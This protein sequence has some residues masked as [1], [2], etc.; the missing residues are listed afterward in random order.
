MAQ[1]ALDNPKAGFLEKNSDLFLA[2]GV[3]AVLMLM[4]VPLSAAVLDMFLVLSIAMSLTVLLLAIYVTRPLDLSLFPTIL[5]L[6]TMYRL[7]LN[8]ASTRLILLNGSQG[9]SAAGVV[10]EAFGQFVVGGDEVV[11]LIVFI[12]INIINFVVITKGA[13]RISEVSARFTLDAMP[14]KQLAIDAD[15]NA[16][17][18]NDREAKERREAVQK[19]ADFYGSMDGASKFVKGDAIAGVLITLINI[20]GGFIIGMVKE[21]LDFTEALSVYT[22][23]TIGDGLV[24]QVPSLIISFSAGML[25]TKV[26]K[27]TDLKTLLVGQMLT[28]YRPMMVVAAILFLIG[29]VPGLPA[30]PFFFMAAIVGGIAFMIK[31]GR[32][33]TQEKQS[34][35][36]GKTTGDDSKPKEEAQSDIPRV[37]DI[38]EIEVGYDLVPLVSSKKNND[39][40]KRILA[41]RKQFAEEMG[42][43]VPPIH[44]QDNLQLKGNE[45]NILLKSVSVGKGELLPGH[46]LAMESGKLIRT[47]DG[48]PTKEPTYNLPALWISEAKK[49][50]A[51]VAGYTVV[52]L[53]SVLATHLSELI[54]KHSHKIFNRQDLQTLLDEFKK[55]YP[56]VVSDLIPELLPF[57]TV[58]KVL[59]NLLKERV[60]IRDLLTILEALASEAPTI[61]DP[62]ALTE[63]VRQSLGPMITSLYKNYKNQIRALGLDKAWEDRLNASIQMTNAGPE[64]HVDPVTSQKLIERVTQKISQHASPEGFP[65]VMCSQNVRPHL[66]N[67]LDKFIPSVVVLSHNE[68]AG[69]ADVLFVDNIA[70]RDK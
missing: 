26:N 11:G 60:P 56:K 21:N 22:I 68:V 30:G 61:K 33:K 20:V 66:F 10:I 18:I 7:A 6:A 5:L 62:S 63:C 16:G 25:V 43:M 14:G 13:G 1:M 28:E 70:E 49:E 59:Q 51:V 47:V 50:D 29:A 41:I 48:I 2:G 67:L 27:E 23:L 38:L 57:G 17:I 12:I 40:V 24:S 58:L 8:L 37:I 64:L 53:G 19:E 15:L 42:I 3:V 4:I 35:L 69:N 52:D 54:R 32:E 46:L 9:A 55:T 65:V 44:I 31:K 36:K 39:L 45:Y 34:L